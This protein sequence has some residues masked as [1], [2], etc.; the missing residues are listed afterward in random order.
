MEEI[1]LFSSGLI[2]KNS[3][4]LYEPFMFEGVDEKQRKTYIDYWK[5]Y[6]E[7]REK[8][9]VELGYKITKMSWKGYSDLL[10]NSNYF[11][12]VN[13]SIY[14]KGNKQV[15]IKILNLIDKNNVFT[16]HITYDKEDKVIDW[17][18]NE[19][20]IIDFLPKEEVCL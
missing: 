7:H 14:S 16:V 10:G 5:N 20:Q 17:Q 18:N 2:C 19:E 11:L 3:V 9:E 15:E 8:K 6:E 13:H 12:Q 4:P 1:K